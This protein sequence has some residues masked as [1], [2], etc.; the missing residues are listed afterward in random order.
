M[1]NDCPDTGLVGFIT[2]VPKPQ[3]LQEG[4][5]TLN[6]IVKSSVSAFPAESWHL[7]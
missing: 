6:D 2:G 5:E 3:S 7:T 1:V 4:E